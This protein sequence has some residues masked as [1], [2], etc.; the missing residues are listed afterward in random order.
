MV[1]N[2]LMILLSSLTL[3]AALLLYKYYEVP[4]L[5]DRFGIEVIEYLSSTPILFPSWNCVKDLIKGVLM[6]RSSGG[7]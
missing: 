5:K 6:V 2:L 4:Y 7:C 1:G 3:S